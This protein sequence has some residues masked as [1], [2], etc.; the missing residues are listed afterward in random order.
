MAE[1]TT[2][3]AG[4][5]GGVWACAWLGLAGL[6]LGA[7]PGSEAKRLS[8]EETVLYV[9]VARPEALLDR[10]T[11]DRVGALL[12]A[13]PGL[14]QGLRD[15][16]QLR[17][18]SQVARF[19]A[20]VLD[21]TPEAGLRAIAGGGA[22]L[23]VE[24]KTQVERVY[25]IVT[26]KDL[27]FAEK[28]HA[29]LV[30]LARQDAEGKGNPDPIKEADY[31]GVHGYSVDSKE[32]HAIVD[33]QVV[34]A[35]GGDALK[36]WIDR[37]QDPKAVGKALAD[38]ASWQAR[39]AAQ[40]PE[41]AAWALARVD[42]LRTLDPKRYAMEKVDPGALFVFGPWIEAAR[43]A[44]WATVSLTWTDARL[45]ANVAVGAPAGSIP[46][47]M[48]GFRPAGSGGGAKA[49]LRPP[50]TIATASLWRDLAA[51]WEARGDIF[52]PEAQQGF[53]QLD[54]FAGQFFGGRDFG[55]GVLGA[56]GQDWRL[57]V[58]RQ[59][60]AKLNPR[61]DVL[62]PGFALV[63][64]LNGE[65]P[66]FAQRLLAA[67]QSFVGLANL[68]A[69]QSKA[70]PLMQ[71]SEA[72]EGVTL[73]TARFLPPKVAAPADE[74]VHIR[75]N[76]SPAVVQ[77]GNQ[78]VF[79]STVELAKALVTTLKA[80]EAATATRSD[81]TLRVEADGRALAALVDQNRGRLVEQ[82]ILEKG[83]DRAR[84]EAEI[85]LLKTLATYLGQGRLAA[86]DTADGASFTLNFALD[87]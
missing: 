2:M 14:E 1:V 75:H 73:S 18:L 84:A 36:A 39:K 42:R 9:E 44:D 27:A 30:E 6:C 65:D 61:P 16:R 72:F 66:D 19:L 17:E 74:P 77:V 29:K 63:V 55:S 7:A 83:N 47:A 40:D 87:R 25:L 4:R 21:T 13:V 82:N 78:F 12:K 79:S 64:D 28:A 22:V 52:P 11:G 48:K 76:L 46:P 59:N 53:A 85:D 57:V 50:G 60:P 86:T 80:G 35:S 71:G 20:T 32:A 3:R 8:A 38:D 5:V 31:K 45:G 56:L 81:Q 37:V 69:A 33:G 49:P 67:Y 15:N 34:I 58:V 68:G 26:P 70:P 23:A 10:L 54:T 43:K 62:L 24:G 41:A 51:V